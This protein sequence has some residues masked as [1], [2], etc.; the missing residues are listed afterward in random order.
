MSRRE[1]T[2]NQ[3]GTIGATER[4]GFYRLLSLVSFLRDGGGSSL[5]RRPAW[6]YAVTYH[7]SC[8]V[9]CTVRCKLLALR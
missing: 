5:H 3:N 4:L 1:K 6:R 8:K 2:A 9:P 7:V